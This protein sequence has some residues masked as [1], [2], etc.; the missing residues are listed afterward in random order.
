MFFCSMGAIWIIQSKLI[1]FDTVI[2]YKLSKM[3]TRTITLKKMTPF[4]KAAIKFKERIKERIA[5]AK[6]IGEQTTKTP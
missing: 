4:M 3:A 2:T 6:P 1:E 5:N